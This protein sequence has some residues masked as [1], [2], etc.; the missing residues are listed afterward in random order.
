MKSLGSVLLS[1]VIGAIVMFLAFMLLGAA[2]KLVAILISIAVV[3]AVYC[4]GRNA[5]EGSR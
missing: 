5:F 3:I 1:I 4:V 2:L